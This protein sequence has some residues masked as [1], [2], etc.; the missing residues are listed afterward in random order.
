MSR[1]E[2]KRVCQRCGQLKM[3]LRTSRGVTFK[4]CGPC[5]R[6]RI[7]EAVAKRRKGFCAITGRSKRQI[8]RDELKFRQT[9][10]WPVT[11]QE[12]KQ[13]RSE[14]KQLRDYHRSVIREYDQDRRAWLRIEAAQLRP[15]K[16]ST[17]HIRH[18]NRRDNYYL[19]KL[20]RSR[21]YRVLKG[22]LKSAPTLE[23]LGCTLPEFRAHMEAQFTPEMTWANHGTY[24]HI[25]HRMPCAV[26]DLS[27]E[28][29]QRWCFHF[30]NLQP[31]EARANISKG[32]KLP[33]FSLR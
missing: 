18:R 29:D 28:F 2:P 32:K 17:A 23:L 20:L 15:Y 5:D 13:Q 33:E 9:G 24:W 4:T 1:W 12:W 8:E 31:L 14:L 25:D 30:T 7:R 10:E 11:R 26:H 6:D 21:I 27:R 16:A 22:K 3:D 19:S